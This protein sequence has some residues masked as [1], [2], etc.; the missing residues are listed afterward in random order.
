MFTLKELEKETEGKIINGNPNVVI[1]LYRCGSKTHIKSEFYVP[2]IFKN[3]N[4]EIYIIDS[5]K[6][7]G[8]G[9]FIEKESSQYKEIV[10]EALSI[11]PNICIIEV[12]NANETICKLGLKVRKQ[13]IDKEIIAVTGSV[14]KTSL[15]NIISNILETEKKVLHDFRNANNNTREFISTDLMTFENYEMGVL[16]LGTARPGR[17]N[18]LSKLVEP[19]IAVI[20]NIGTAHLNTFKTQKGILEEK[21]HITNFIKDKK[22]L[23][24]NSDDEYLK[25]LQDTEN[26]RIV[27][28][29]IKEACDITEEEGKLSFKTNIYGKET[30]FHLNL[31]GKHY[32]TNIILA[33]KIAEMYQISYEN[34]I[35]GIQ[36]YHPI[37]G[38]FKVWKNEKKDIILIDDSYSS[39]F[40]SVKL[41]LE[42]SNKMQS[43]RRIAV[44]GKMAALGEQAPLLHEKLGE[45]FGNLEFDYLYLNGEFTKHVFKG[46]LKYIKENKIKKF[47]NKELL[48]EE[49]EKNIK[50]GDL[51]YIKASNQ[52]NFSEIVDALKKKYQLKADES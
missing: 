24:I 46:A 28:Y 26:Y 48:I 10:N 2:I 51:I 38:R 42:I 18:Q 17:M 3:V 32:I 43:K 21:L 44:L 27:K 33:I 4:R 22:L 6:N 7:G 31:Y 29:S 16:E 45:L 30:E 15:C 5:V 49:L 50:E 12:E 23:F 1:S 13:N 47:K 8:I 34:I 40:E 20:H 36:N 39:S 35:K 25:E 37:D 41:G 14:G 9:F 19:S 11:N 52:Q